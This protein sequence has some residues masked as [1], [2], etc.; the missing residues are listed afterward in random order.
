MTLSLNYFC[1]FFCRWK[2]CELATCS[3]CPSPWPWPPYWRQHR[4]SSTASNWVTVTSWYDHCT[5]VL[6]CSYV[7]PSA[8]PAVSNALCF[9]SSSL[10]PAFMKPQVPNLPGILTSL[11]RFFLFWKF[12]SANQNSPYK[13]LRIWEGRKTF[14][15]TGWR[16]APVA[17]P[18]A[19]PVDP[20]ETRWPGVG[21]AASE[22]PPLGVDARLLLFSRNCKSCFLT[23]KKFAFLVC[24]Y[25]KLLLWLQ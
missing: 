16:E 18:V 8:T 20:T 15:S 9:S 3:V 5:C 4:G 13:Q 21:H 10:S 7:S 11:I 1:S 25:L 22:Q 14:L 17:G 6:F 23:V 2:W 24:F 12:G 19:G